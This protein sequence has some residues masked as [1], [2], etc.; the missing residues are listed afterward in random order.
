M[1]G[2]YGVGKGKKGCDSSAYNHASSNKGGDMKGYAPPKPIGKGM[3]S[4]SP[5]IK[6][7]AMGKGHANTAGS[8]KGKKKPSGGKGGVGY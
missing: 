2:G 4:A 3:P 1:K 8:M 5:D 6:T 7:P